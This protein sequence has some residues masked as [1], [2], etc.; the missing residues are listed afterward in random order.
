MNM[1]K[2]IHRL[3]GVIAGVVIAALIAFAAIGG[4]IK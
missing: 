4:L 3:Q 1:N 2:W